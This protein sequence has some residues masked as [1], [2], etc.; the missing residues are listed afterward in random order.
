MNQRD[1]DIREQIELQH[2]SQVTQESIQEELEEAASY[3]A[4]TDWWRQQ[5]LTGEQIARQKAGFDAIT[6]A[7]IEGIEN[8]RKRAGL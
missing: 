5:G 1:T 7:L 3:E 8:K 2:K 6:K 4:P